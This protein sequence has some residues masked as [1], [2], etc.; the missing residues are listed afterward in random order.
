MKSLS[1]LKQLL[2]Q[3]VSTLQSSDDELVDKILPLVRE[4]MTT[5][6]QFMPLA[7]FFFA[8]PKAFE[9]PITTSLI[10]LLNEVLPAAEWKHDVL[11][12]LIRSTAEAR[13]VKVKDLFMELR[14]AV[15]GKTVGPPLLESLEILGKEET[16][17]RLT[18]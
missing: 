18:V 12:S 7:G 15:T 11:E 16:L 6:S 13:N 10:Q 5:L 3:H 8:R 14:L 17:A 4:R 2:Y 9:K 1:E